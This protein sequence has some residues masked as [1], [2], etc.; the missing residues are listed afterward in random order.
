MRFHE[1][2][3]YMRDHPVNCSTTVIL[4]LVKALESVMSF[5]VLPPAYWHNEWS[6]ERYKEY[7]QAIEKLKIARF[8]YRKEVIK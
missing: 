2:E 5:M 1:G 7:R 8:E 3:D 6:D 4:E